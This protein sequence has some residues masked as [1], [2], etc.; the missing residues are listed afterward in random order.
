MNN[1]IMTSDPD[2]AGVFLWSFGAGGLQEAIEI[3]HN[4]LTGM[5]V[6]VLVFALSVTE[7]P[8]ADPG[9]FVL[10]SS[11]ALGVIENLNV[12]KNSE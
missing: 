9:A 2:G 8:R 5:S 12:R 10:D 6:P 11:N 7:D 4:D 1:T 3:K